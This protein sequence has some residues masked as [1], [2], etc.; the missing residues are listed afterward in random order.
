MMVLS[1]FVTFCFIQQT[2]ALALKKL[3]DKLLSFSGRGT[4]YDVGPGSCGTTDDDSDMVVAINKEQMNNG[5]NPNNNPNCHKKIKIVGELG[6]TVTARVVDTCPGCDNGSVDMSPAGK[7]Y[8]VPLP[9]F[10]FCFNNLLV[11]EK[12]CGSLALGVCSIRWG[13]A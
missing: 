6:K 8:N 5:A 13:F 12:V 3:T 2:E 7:I 9:F 1:F 10:C 4:Y 11:F